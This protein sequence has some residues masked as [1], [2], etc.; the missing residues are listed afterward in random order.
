MKN[1][2]CSA[3]EKKQI[4]SFYYNNRQRFVEPYLL[5]YS[6]NNELTLSA[7]QLSGGTQESWRQFHLSKISSLAITDRNF[8]PS[9]QGYNPNDSTMSQIVCRL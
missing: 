4:I 9:R 2:I 8:V 3:I 6:Q 5:G 7:W 1:N